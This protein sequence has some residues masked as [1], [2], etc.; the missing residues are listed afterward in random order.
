V[1]ETLKKVTGGKAENALELQH[2]RNRH[3]KR[4]ITGRSLPG[5]TT[6]SILLLP[7][8]IPLQELSQHMS[9]S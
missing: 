5:E 9:E 8:N 4:E 2:K 6:L 3:I 7:N 1:D